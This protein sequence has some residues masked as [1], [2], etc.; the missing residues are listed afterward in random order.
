[1]GIT[2]REH[3]ACDIFCAIIGA[4]Y[5]DD[6]DY[7]KRTAEKAVAHADVLIAELERTAALKAA[8]EA[9]KKKTGK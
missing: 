2:D 6:P 3:T 8:A 1:M 4:H 5:S 9:K 7:I